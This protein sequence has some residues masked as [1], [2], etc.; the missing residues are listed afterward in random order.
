MKLLGSREKWWEV[1]EVIIMRL[2]TRKILGSG[3]STALVPLLIE[4]RRPLMGAFCLRNDGGGN[5]VTCFYV[6]T[7]IKY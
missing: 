7:E 2:V 6:L 3:S 5:F 1:K 4:Y